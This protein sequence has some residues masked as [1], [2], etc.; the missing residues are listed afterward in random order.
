MQKVVPLHKHIVEFKERESFFHSLLK[1]LRRKHFVYGKIYADI[2]QEVYVIEIEKPIGIIRDDRSV[3]ALEVYEAGHLLFETLDVMV[4][5]FSRHHLAHV[6][7]AGGVAYHARASA[8]KSDGAVSVFLHPRHSH[9][10]NVMTYM[11]TVRCRVESDVKSDAF[12]F[13]F[14]SEIVAV[15]G[16]FYKSA[17]FENVHNV[18]HFFTSRAESFTS[19]QPNNI[20]T[21]KQYKSKQKNLKITVK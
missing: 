7:S 9:N 4:N 3:F 15:N 2:A 12:G 11:Q 1:A 14:L 6:R 5:R 19:P 20:L 8:E 13:E 10:R 18:F 17:F 21:L 16:L